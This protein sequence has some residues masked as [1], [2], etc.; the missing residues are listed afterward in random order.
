MQGS[1]FAHE[2][3]LEQN[4]HGTDATVSVVTPSK[5]GYR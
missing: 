3:D 4:V 5:C 1:K 2:M